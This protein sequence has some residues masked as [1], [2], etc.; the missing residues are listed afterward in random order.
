MTQ[1]SFY[2]DWRILP[3]RDAEWRSWV[4]VGWAKHHEFLSYSDQNT[5]P[6]WAIQGAFPVWFVWKEFAQQKVLLRSAS[7]HISHVSWLHHADVCYAPCMSLQ[8]NKKTNMCLTLSFHS[9]KRKQLG[10]FMILACKGGG[11]LPSHDCA[12]SSNSWLE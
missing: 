12:V 6:W 2:S 7:L 4:S 5:D 3:S 9:R 1:G 8:P 10:S 11:T